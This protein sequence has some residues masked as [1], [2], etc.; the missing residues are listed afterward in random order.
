MSIEGEAIN[1]KISQQVGEF[2]SVD[3]QQNA[4]EEQPTLARGSPTAAEMCTGFNRARIGR[5]PRSTRRPVAQFRIAQTRLDPT[6]QQLV[7]SNAFYRLELPILQVGIMDPLGHLEHGLVDDAEPLHQR[8][9]HA[10][11]AVLRELHLEQVVGN[12]IRMP[13][14]VVVE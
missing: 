13:L 2:A 7:D 6:L 9:E 12:R 3:L 11:L 1:S 14:R 8:L 4:P 5:A 10:I